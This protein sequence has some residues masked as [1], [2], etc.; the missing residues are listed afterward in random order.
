[1]NIV[2]TM[3]GKYSRFRIFASKIPK[4][5]LPLGNQSILGEVIDQIKFSCPNAKFYL[6]ANRHD[7]IFYPILKAIMLKKDIPLAHL[8]YIDDTRSQLETAMKSESLI[9]ES[10]WDDPVAFTN[11]DT[12]IMYRKSYY[13]E[14]SA[15]KR[16]EALLDVFLGKSSQYSYV[17]FVGDQL[18]HIVDK[19]VV[20]RWAC[21][22][23][24]G[25]GSFG[26]VKESFSELRSVKVEGNFTDLYNLLLKKNF[27]VKVSYSSKKADT[28]ILGTPEEYTINIHRF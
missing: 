10:E 6:I 28:V 26:F 7:Q 21:S 9:G 4:Y 5:L 27:E 13:E 20:S 16:D 23:L 15:L 19:R 17:G 12:I 25:F 24:Y 22:G 11:I 14:L 3:A 8:V 1:M 18:D 2:L